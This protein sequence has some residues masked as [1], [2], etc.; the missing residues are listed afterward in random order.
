MTQDD[1]VGRV[2]ICCVELV[3]NAGLV[4]RETLTLVKEDGETQGELVVSYKFEPRGGG[5]ALLTP[6]DNFLHGK[7]VINIH[8]ANNLPNADRHIFASSD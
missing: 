6:S 7:L 1:M 5:H 2:D 3:R 8:R 4:T